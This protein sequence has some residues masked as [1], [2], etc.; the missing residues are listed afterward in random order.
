MSVAIVLKSD[1]FSWKAIQAFKIASALSFKTKVYFIAIKEGV[2][3]LTDW[4][5]TAL[6][7]EDFRTYPVNGENLTVVIERD[8]FTI[9]G[10]SE[11]NL[12]IGD[13][14]R[15]MADEEEIAKLLDKSSVV[16]VW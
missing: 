14:K 5:P 7:Y 6:G 15:V 12:W 13:F 3:F 2:Y 1:P 9:R 11:N 4:E 16:G 8:D 10:L